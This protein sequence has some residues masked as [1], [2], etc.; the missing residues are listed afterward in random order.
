[1]DIVDD[2][3]ADLHGVPRAEAE[4]A[5][6]EAVAAEPAAVAAAP[7]AAAAAAPEQQA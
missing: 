5:E 2:C 1:L 7:D 3:L 6:P 4:E